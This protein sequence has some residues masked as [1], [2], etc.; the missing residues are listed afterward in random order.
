MHVEVS[1]QHECELFF[2]AQICF[3]CVIR[4]L[5]HLEQLESDRGQF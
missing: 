2:N 5:P 1:G 4:V 3:V